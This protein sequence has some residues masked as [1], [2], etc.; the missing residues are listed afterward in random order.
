M[1]EKIHKNHHES[2]G[3]QE[4]HKEIKEHQESLK[5]KLEKDAKSTEHEHS[6]NIE[7]IRSSI[8]K[9]SKSKNEIKRHKESEKS[10]KD[11]PYLVN[12]ELKEIAFKRTLK[13]TQSKL[14]AEQRVFSKLIHQPTVEKISDLGSKTVARPSGI[15]F[16]GIFSFIGS[17]FFLWASKYYGFEYNFLL[18]LI[19]FIGGFF[20]GLIVE[21]IFKLFFRNKK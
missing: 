20:L 17:S 21:L 7:H 1:S 12:K 4:V 6:K 9:E 8:E 10:E 5:G 3:S 11:Q 15:L 13:K 2:H 14:P 18:F 19:F 16:G